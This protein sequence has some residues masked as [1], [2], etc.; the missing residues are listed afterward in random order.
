MMA[1]LLESRDDSPSVDLIVYDVE[2]SDGTIREF[3]SAN[4]IAENMLTQVDSDGYS[5]TLMKGIADYQRKEA[6]VVSKNDGYDV[7]TKHGQKQL[8]KNEKWMAMAWFVGVR[9]HGCY[10]KTWKS[11][12][13]LKLWSLCEIEWDSWWICFCVVGSRSLSWKEMW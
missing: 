12:I 13:Q 7:V 11:L 1:L 6:G 2:F 5:L 8:W 3:D 9:N 10:W 4:L